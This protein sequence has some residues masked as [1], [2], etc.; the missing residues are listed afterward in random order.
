M[1]NPVFLFIPHNLYPL[2]FNFPFFNS[3]FLVV[4][5]IIP[6]LVLVVWGSE[7]TL[8]FPMPT[9]QKFVR[10]G[11][12]NFVNQRPPS[13]VVDTH[14]RWPTLTNFVGSASGMFIY[15]LKDLLLSKNL[16]RHLLWWWNNILCIKITFN[17][18]RNSPSWFYICKTIM[19]WLF[20]RVY[21]KRCS[22]K[23]SPDLSHL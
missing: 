10:V 21:S 3:L 9:R 19:L 11:L 2:F 1:W 6:V 7:E 5:F 12:E 18:V 17:Q 15:F 23:A 13:A 4:S 22:L 8:E 14:S 20:G 16:I